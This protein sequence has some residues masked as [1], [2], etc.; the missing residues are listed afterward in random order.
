MATQTLLSFKAGRSFRREG[1][2][3]VDASPVK[4]SLELLR[5]D[6]ELLHLLW[7]NRATGQVEDVRSQS[8]SLVKLPMTRHIGP[9]HISH[10]GSIPESSPHCRSNLCFEV[11]F[12]KP[13]TLC[14]HPFHSRV[15]D[16]FS[17]IHKFWMQV[18]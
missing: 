6:D 8:L 12:F 14:E 2:S 16:L 17:S 7:K 1:S 9:D 3:F 5:G 13:A 10:G 4:G 18:D 15:F 11:F